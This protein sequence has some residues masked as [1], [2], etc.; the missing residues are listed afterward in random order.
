MKILQNI[1]PKD[2]KTMIKGPILEN[3]IIPK[4]DK[5]LN[6]IIYKDKP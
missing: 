3:R 5:T 1:I 6:V 4:M 2:N